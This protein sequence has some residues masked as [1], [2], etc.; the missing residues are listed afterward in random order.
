MARVYCGTY[1]KYN[2]GSLN[3]RWMDLED[4][5]DISEFYDACKEVHSD[6]HDPELMFQDYEGFPSHY[7]GESYIKPEVYDYIGLDEHIRP[8]F[9]ELL[10]SGIDEI[11]PEYIIY[12]SDGV[13]EHN[14]LREIAY[15]HAENGLI[16]LPDHLER[17]F[18]YEA[19]GRDRDIEG[20][21]FLTK[22]GTLFEYTG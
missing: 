21:Y 18:D 10:D 15:Y 9:A 5:S 16:E 11:N 14:K 3:G 13:S 20:S 6:E 8:L 7:Y 22:S 12:I 1:A 19:Y 2:S 17:Y 4:Y